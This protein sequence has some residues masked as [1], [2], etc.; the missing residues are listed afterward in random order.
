MG[1]V[2]NRLHTRTTVMRIFSIV[3]VILALGALANG[4]G[5]GYSPRSARQVL[6]ELAKVENCVEAS[7][8][9]PCET[10][11]DSEDNTQTPPEDDT[12]TPSTDLL[13][14][15]LHA[16]KGDDEHKERMQ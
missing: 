16:S 11:T 13:R 2:A 14:R 9:Q 15:N 5:K 8:P 1:F 10:S 12:Q 6:T 4:R 3:L 7:V